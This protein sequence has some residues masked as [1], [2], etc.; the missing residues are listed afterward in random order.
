M[1]FKKQKFI[2]YL[3]RIRRFVLFFIYFFAY[4]SIN[5]STF[6]I[7]GSPSRETYFNDYPKYVLPSAEE[8]VTI[9]RFTS[10]GFRVI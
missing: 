3:I 1:W 8:L 2:N 4:K 10:V 5:S 9:T 6:S 7:G